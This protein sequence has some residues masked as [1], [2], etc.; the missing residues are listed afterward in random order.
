MNAPL[1]IRD[2]STRE[3][4]NALRGYDY[5]TVEHT[6][7]VYVGTRVTTNGPVAVYATLSEIK[8][9]LAT[10]PHLNSKREGKLIRR[11]MS[12]T[13]QPEQWLRAHPTYGK[14]I[15]DVSHPQRRPIPKEEY[16]RLKRIL[17]KYVD[18][19]YVIS[20]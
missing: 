11:L 10:R 13:G 4:V 18:E 6:D 14:M 7:P 19:Q 8:G 9:V 20:S 1:T 16:V 12:A 2:M 17:G 5:F 3:L 15:G